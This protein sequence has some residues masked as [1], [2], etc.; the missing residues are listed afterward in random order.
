MIGPGFSEQQ[1]RDLVKY[2]MADINSTYNRNFSI[3]ETKEGD[4]QYGVWVIYLEE[5]T[6]FACGIFYPLQRAHII[7][8]IQD[9][10]NSL[11]NIHLL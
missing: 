1:A 8:L 9:G 5:K 6:C 2:K 10:D 3:G 11:E 7:P 4:T